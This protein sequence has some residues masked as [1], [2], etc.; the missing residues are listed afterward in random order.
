MIKSV[1]YDI[2][3]AIMLIT[4]SHHTHRHFFFW[5]I[6]CGASLSSAIRTCQYRIGFCWWN[7]W[8]LYNCRFHRWEFNLHTIP[9]KKNQSWII[10]PCNVFARSAHMPRIRSTDEKK[11]KTKIRKIFKIFTK[12][13]Y[14]R[15][16]RERPWGHCLSGD[17]LAI[18]T[19]W[20]ARKKHVYHGQASQHLVRSA[21]KYSLNDIDRAMKWQITNCPTNWTW[22]H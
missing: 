18:Y 10:E 6:N 5:Q 9:T 4:A 17:Q 14:L 1:A 2:E 13:T 20:M 7:F 8:K 22:T 11:K 19:I 15:A 3:I 16:R 12:T 21:E